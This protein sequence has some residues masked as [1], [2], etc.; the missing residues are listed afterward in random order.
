MMLN[1]TNRVLLLLVCY[2]LLVNIALLMHGR[3]EAGMFILIGAVHVFHRMEQQGQLK[4]L[5]SRVT[6]RVVELLVWLAVLLFVI[7]IF[8][9]SSATRNN[10]SMCGRQSTAV[11]WSFPATAPL[12]SLLSW[13]RACFYLSVTLPS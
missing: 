6:L 7:K 2:G 11:L 4:C 1:P 10:T 9:H 3:Y 5:G 13:D 8:W 12:G